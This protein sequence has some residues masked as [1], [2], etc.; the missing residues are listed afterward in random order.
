MFPYFWFI[1]KQIYNF[2]NG[3]DIS[4]CTIF[5]I[6]FYQTLLLI[7]KIRRFQI[8]R[9]LKLL[10]SGTINFTVQMTDNFYCVLMNN[11]N[12]VKQIQVLKDKQVIS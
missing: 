4:V 12:I 6:Q 7:K 8:S 9:L 2:R 3:R 5:C 1:L 11:Q 10:I